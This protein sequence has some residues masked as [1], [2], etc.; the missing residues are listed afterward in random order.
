MAKT[1]KIWNRWKEKERKEKDKEG[2]KENTC[3]D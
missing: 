2:R 1:K 3:E